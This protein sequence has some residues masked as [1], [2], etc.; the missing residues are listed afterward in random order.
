MTGKRFDQDVAM[1]HVGEKVKLGRKLSYIV[2][3]EQYGYAPLLHISLFPT[4][5]WLNDFL[6]SIQNYIAVFGKWIF[7][8]NITFTFPFTHYD[9]D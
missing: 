4:L 5:I 9:L 7:D 3:K 6:G 1:N 2:F 8:S